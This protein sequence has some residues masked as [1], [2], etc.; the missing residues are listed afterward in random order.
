IFKNHILKD[1]GHL[2]INDIKID[3][4]QSVLNEWY[5][6]SQSKYKE[7]FNYAVK[8]IDY[9]IHLELVDTNTNVLK[10][11]I[12]PRKREQIENEEKKKFYSKE[13]LLIFLETLR[14]LENQKAY[15]LFYL[16]AFSGM[17]KG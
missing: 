1:F 14:S 4:A 8:I 2:D 5:N 10:K 17:R 6:H 13:E 16:L 12:I 3:Y 11:L 7:Y 9:A 15:T